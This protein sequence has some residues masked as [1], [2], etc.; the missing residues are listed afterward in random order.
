MKLLSISILL[1]LHSVLLFSQSANTNSLVQIT[2]PQA[3]AFAADSS[4]AS[5]KAKNLYLSGYWQYRT[6][7][8]GRLPLVSLDLM[9]VAY[10]HNFVKRYDSQ[11]NVDVYKSQQSLNSN[12]NISVK[13]Q[14]DLTGGTFYIDTELGRLQNFG[15]SNYEQYSSVPFRIGYSQSLFGFNAYKWDKQIEPLR[16]V[17]AKKELIY[18]IEEIA[19]QA[20]MLFFEFAIS[21]TAFTLAKQNIANMDTLFLIGEERYKVGTI[22]QSDLLN[23]K[24]RLINAQNDL[25]NAEISRKRSEYGLASFLGMSS[26]SHFE[27]KLPTEVFKIDLI[28]TDVL[29]KAKQNNPIYLEQKETVLKSK[30]AYNKVLKESKF[31]ATLS[32]SVGFN[33]IATGIVDAYRKPLQQDL[34]S[35]NMRIPLVDWGISKGKINVARQHLNT[36]TVTA[37]QAEQNFEQD[38]LM[39]VHEYKVRE[40]QIVRSEEA[41]K[42]AQSAYNKAKQLFAIGKADVNSVNLAISSQIEAELNYIV[43]LKNYWLSFYKIRKLALFDY[44]EYKNLAVVYVLSE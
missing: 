5:L 33:Q 37:H 41:K 1:L 14:L 36:I 32:A 22:S 4:L 28:Y 29:N 21:H 2:L 27:L 26:E 44:V 10:N 30:Q 20:T 9:P 13:Q 23:L 12:A 31:S 43:S 3:I 40:S 34:V 24:L 39:A 8:A 38:V 7:K 16:F 11:N 19:E 17:K 25:G 6:F 42:I 35:L 15:L 18:T